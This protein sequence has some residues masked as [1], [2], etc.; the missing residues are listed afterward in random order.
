MCASAKVTA[1]WCHWQ[2]GSEG[3]GAFST[4]MDVSGKYSQPSNTNIRVPSAIP[5]ILTS[6][7]HLLYLRM[8]LSREKYLCREKSVCSVSVS[9]NSSIGN[10]PDSLRS[11]LCACEIL[12]KHDVRVPTE[13]VIQL[14]LYI[15][16]IRALKAK[17]A[18]N[19]QT[20]NQY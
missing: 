1:D 6:E 18:R 2:W 8:P 7:R 3:T 5:L 20:L 17:K 9:R 4:K 12:I 16:R 15:T 10:M 13:K 14:L 19:A 11:W